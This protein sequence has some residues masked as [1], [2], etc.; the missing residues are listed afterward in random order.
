MIAHQPI[1][2]RHQ[3]AFRP[4]IGGQSKQ[5]RSAFFGGQIGINVAA[6]KPING[7]FGVAHQKSGRAIVNKT[8]FK[9]GILHGIGVLKFVH[10]NH[11]KRCGQPFGQG[12]SVF[13]LLQSRQQLIQHIRKALYALFF[14]LLRGFVLYPTQ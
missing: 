1:G 7:L 3:L 8:L 6:A 9:N 11:R 4:K 12:L 14:D 13:G 2:R 5:T 10:Q